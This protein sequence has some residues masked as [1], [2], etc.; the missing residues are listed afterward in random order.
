MGTERYQK[1]REFKRSL[2]EIEQQYIEFFSKRES[3]HVNE[4]HDRL[5]DHYM[6]ISDNYHVKFGFKNDTD[7]PREIIDKCMS[8]F[9]RIFNAK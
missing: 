1:D 8:E 9:I 5:H 7:L 3:N 6:M 2:L 4:E